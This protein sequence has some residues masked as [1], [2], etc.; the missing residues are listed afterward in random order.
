MNW[1]PV[2]ECALK[3]AGADILYA[4]YQSTASVWTMAAIRTAFG[5]VAKKVLGPVGVTI[6]AIEFGWCI[7][8]NRNEIWD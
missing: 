1:S 4:L 8:N 6:A 7:W 5:T 2:G 3:A